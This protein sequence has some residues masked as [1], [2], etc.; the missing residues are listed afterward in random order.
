MSDDTE[1]VEKV[2]HDR[3]KNCDKRLKPHEKVDGRCSKCGC[4][5]P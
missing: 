3:C 5:D 2:K 1:H 4:Y